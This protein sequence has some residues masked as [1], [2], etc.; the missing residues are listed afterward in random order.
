MINIL[1]AD[2]HKIFREGVAK[3]I[4]ETEIVKVIGEAAN[5]EE[6]LEF[7]KFKTV[8]VI[9]MDMN[10]PVLDGIK[11]TEIVKSTHPEIKIIM[12]S[13]HETYE[14]IK[15]SLDIGVDGYLLKTT[16]KEEIIAAIKD[17]FEG[18]NYFSKEVL[19]IVS[20]EFAS[21]NSILPI[22]LTNREQDVLILICKEKNSNEIANE[23]CIST[24]TVETHRKN[25]LSKT[26]SKNVAGLV[27]FGL[28]NNII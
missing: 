9:L 27:K 21:E 23:L 4:N 15:A 1:I 13:M 22:K 20:N 25:L 24:Y 2:D 5:G 10:M 18:V 8:D 26:G 3:L 17:V 14:Y 12:L 19:G 7:L 16:S 28:N 11:T 6:V